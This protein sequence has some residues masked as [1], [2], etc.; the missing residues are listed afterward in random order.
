MTLAV[1]P[2]RSV[3]H[4]SRDGELR[5][6]DAAGNTKARRQA[7]RLLPRRR[8]P[9]RRRRRPEVR[10]NRFDLPL[11]R[12]PA[13][14][15]RG[16]RPGDRH[17]RGL[18]EVRRRQP[19]L[20]LRPEDRRHPRQRQR[21]E[22][23]RRPRLPR[24]L[25]PRRRRHRLRQ[26]RQPLPV[27]GRRLQPLRLRRL[28]AH[29]RAGEP[30]PRL[31]R[32][33]QRRQHQRPARQDP[34]HQGRTPTARTRS[35]TATSSPPGTDKTRPEI[36]AMGFRNPFRLQRRQAD[37]HRL[38]R[39]LRP[40]RGRRRPGPRPGR[41]GRVRPR[42]QARATS[43]GRTAPAT[44]TPTS[45]TTSRRAPPAQP[46]DCA[47]PKNTSPHNTGLTDLPPAQAAWIPYDGGSVPEFGTG[48]ESPMGGPV[49][50]YD[51]A[52]D[53]PVK[54]PEA[55][56]GDFFAGEFGRRWIKRIEQRRQTAPSQSINDVPVDRHPG[57]GHGVRPR[58]RAV[59]PRLR[60]RLVRR[61]RELRPC[62]ASRT[63]PTATPRSPRRRRTAPRAQ[64][65]LK[66][67]F[68]SAGPPTR[69]ATP[70]PTPGTSATAAPRPR[71]TPRTRTR[72]TAPT[73]R[74]SPPRTRPAAPAAPSVQI[75]V[76]N[77]APKVTLE[78]PGD[79]AAVH[80]RRRDPVQGEG[81]RPRGRPAIDCTKVKVTYI[82]GHDSHGHP[83][84]SANGCAGT[85]QT[86][87]DGD[88]DPDANIFGVFDAEYTDGGGGGQAALTTHDQN[89]RPA[90]APPGR[91]LRHLLGRLG[92]RQGHAHTA[93]RP[94]ATSTTATGSP[95]RRTSSDNAKKITARVS[96]GG[97]GGTLE[98][99]SG[100][101]RRARSSARTTVPATG[102]WETFQDVS[103]ALSRAPRGTTTLYLV[104]K[105]SGSGA[106]TTWTT[107]PSPPA[108]GR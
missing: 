72:R 4:T 40:R 30:Q 34:A 100:L 73:P 33:A 74:P 25:L 52:L 98:I 86:S 61:R 28:H 78:L 10:E 83:V 11:L 39:R 41:P 59:R 63:P 58:R 9:P 46:F 16:R 51:A 75:V 94:S 18:Q 26:G 43:A 88:H 35:P 23:P 1:L 81:H 89:V 47:A 15:P 95:S 71:R 96:S 93:A 79:G 90:Q 67:A 104:F 37:R 17:R 101:G 92:H 102:G 55:Y 107:S 105:G 13:G 106:S 85:L 68:T 49:Y 45:T 3:L 6:T 91:A 77:T 24:H 32:P 20:P 22:D 5:L 97:A 29:R 42:H 7:R 87:A 44:T 48:S 27:D 21:E 69:T 2:D 80:L 14:H 64:A 53:S 108:E 82:L 103:A 56:D 99:R 19:P 57:H 36:Y 70:S 60:H 66:V 50:R 8:G 38:R 65:P 76:G 31:R 12:A 54:F 84:T 62:T